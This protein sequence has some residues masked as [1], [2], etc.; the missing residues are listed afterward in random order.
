MTDDI[1]YSVEFAT[2]KPAKDLEEVW[3]NFDPTLIIDPESDQYAPRHDPVLS[4]RN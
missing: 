4:L 3:S 2:I 1:Q